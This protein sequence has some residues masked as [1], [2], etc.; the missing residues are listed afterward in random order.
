MLKIIIPARELYDEKNNT[1]IPVKE[2]SIQLEHS[3]VSISKW[4]AK[5]HKAFLTKKQKTD[6]EL[7]DYIRCMTITQNVSDYVY[8]GITPNIINQITTYINESMSATCLP[9][10]NNAST[11][12]DTI[13]SELIYYWMVALNIPFSCEKWHLNRLLTLIS[14]CNLKNNPGK[15]MGNSELYNRNRSLN[16]ARK[17]QH[18][19]HG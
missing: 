7:R 6:E 4:E 11:N 13:T 14:I 19:T 10:N 9:K 16:N 1:F 3:L 12:R 2:A 8:Y 18:H 15:K 17:A 5:W